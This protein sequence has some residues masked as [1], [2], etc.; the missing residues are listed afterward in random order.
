MSDYDTGTSQEEEE[1]K[2][3]L[4]SFA[5]MEQF[6]KLRDQYY[7]VVNETDPDFLKEKEKIVETYKAQYDKLNVTEQCERDRIIQL[8]RFYQ[9]IQT[10]NQWKVYNHYLI[11][12]C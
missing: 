7:N 2:I 12:L 5:L 11:E 8:G 3:T 1:D 6:M 9:Q 10:D 4:K